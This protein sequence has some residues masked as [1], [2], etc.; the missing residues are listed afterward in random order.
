MCAPSGD[1]GAAQA[2]ADEA[3]RQQRIREG[4]AAIDKQFAGF[5]D[6]YFKERENAFVKQATPLL[7]NAFTGEKN[8]AEVGLAA[9]GMTDSSNAAKVAAG[10]QGGYNAKAAEIASSAID[11]S[12]RLRQT[13]AENR[14]TLVG[15]LNGNENAFQAGRDAMSKANNLANSMNTS[16]LPGIVS[17]FA[18]AYGAAEQGRRYSEGGKGRGG[19]GM[20]GFNV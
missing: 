2:R 18:G 6:N 17:G 19:A 7:N 8:K 14:N 1:G 3:A 11:Q 4:T 16:M 9:N 12:N 10:L 20:F 13:V 15:Q 5:D